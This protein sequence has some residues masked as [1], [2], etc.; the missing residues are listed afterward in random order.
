MP[1]ITKRLVDG[2]TAE[3]AGVIVRDDELKGFGVRRNRDGTI[4]YLVEYRA[5]RG[6]N[7]PVKRVSLGRHG[8][9]TA[10]QARFQ[11]K[12][13]LVA[14][15]KGDDPAA[16]RIAKNK[17]LTV[18]DLL[19]RTIN[20]HWTAL[21]RKSAVS[22]ERMVRFSLL[23][24]F[25]NIK[26]SDLKRAEIRDW[27]SSQSHRPRQAN[28]DLALLHKALNLAVTDE[29]IV[30]NPASGLVKFPE[31]RR[32]RRLTD[33]ELRNIWQASSDEVIGK[34]AG[35]LFR[36]LICT[37]CRKGEWLNSKWSDIDFENRV[38][39]L[40]DAKAGARDVPLNSLSVSLLAASD[41]ASEWVFCNRSGNAPLS[42]SRVQE[43]WKKLL[44][45]AELGDVHV[46]DLRHSFASRGAKLGAS[47][48]V[49]RDALGHKTLS[50][51]SRY[52]AE[53]MEA[54]MQL[55]EVIGRDLEVITAPSGVVEHG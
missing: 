22:F 38:L 7:F 39:R 46:H 13:T 49:L 14:V 3:A 4:T 25:G 43:A 37:G 28:L 55:S 48:L 10:E 31:K 23:P 2:L 45:L 35:L 27:H 17:E 36:L 1:K 19:E 30:S 12:E 52:V 33:Q 42:A 24:R 9:L 5:G 18:G 16:N 8:V 32:S 47:A 20:S 34:E 11:A 51:T 15:Q 50:M 29:L 44:V 6:R 26:L 40:S 53:Q 21:E 54:V 41:N